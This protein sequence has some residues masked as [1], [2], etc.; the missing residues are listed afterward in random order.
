MLDKIMKT[1]TGIFIGHAR[2]HFENPALKKQVQL[3]G[4][5]ACKEDR[6][7]KEER[8]LKK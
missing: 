5:S 6:R 2:W 4:K 3:V 7:L 1:M 8:Q